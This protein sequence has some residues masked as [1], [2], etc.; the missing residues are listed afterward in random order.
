[1]KLKILYFF[2][3]YGVISHTLS[4]TVCSNFEE[5]RE[6]AESG[7]VSSQMELGMRFANGDGINKDL[8]KANAWF[9]EAAK[10][11]NID[12]MFNI[13]VSYQTGSGVQKDHKE[14]VEWY[15]KASKR[16]H[17]KASLLLGDLFF[18][19]EDVLHDEK[20]GTMAYL[21]YRLADSQGN[22]EAMKIVEIIHSNM[23]EIEK[24]KSDQLFSLFIQEW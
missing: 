9:L 8:S 16:G 18:K 12:G 5:C 3:L 20:K 24:M 11:G 14:A 13:G 23:P 10:Q 17:G 1:M 22:K 6:R 7:D 21:Y 2:L 4:D 15:Q 19:G